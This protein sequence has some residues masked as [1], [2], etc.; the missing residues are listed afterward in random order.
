MCQ[1]RKFC[2]DLVILTNH[3]RKINAVKGKITYNCRILA[4]I[5]LIFY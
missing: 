5:L 3:D 4:T 1:L 2:K